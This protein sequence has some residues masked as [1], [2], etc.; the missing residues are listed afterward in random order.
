MENK[1][2][3]KNIQQ[4]S[5]LEEE[6]FKDVIKYR[7]IDIVDHSIIEKLSYFPKNL[8]IDYHNYFAFSKENTLRDLERDFTNCKNELER[9]RQYDEMEYIKSL[10]NRIAFL[11]LFIELAKKYDW[12]A[13]DNLNRAFENRK[14]KK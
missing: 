11:E 7:K 6:A 1:F 12:C 2:E 8:F 4:A 10:E 13:C 5:V 3:Q 14:I 9:I